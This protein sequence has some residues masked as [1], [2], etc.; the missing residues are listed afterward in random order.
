MRS[1]A[2]VATRSIRACTP[3]RGLRARGPGAADRGR[4][5][6]KGT[7]VTAT[8]QHTTRLISANSGRGFVDQ[9]DGTNRAH[10]STVATGVA[11]MGVMH[12]GALFPLVGFEGKQTELTGRD[13]PA[14]TRAARGIHLGDLGWRGG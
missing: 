4:H 3:G 11:Q 13:T 9:G 7:G 10:G 8:A 5:T 14:T 12:D 2:Q 1:A 6:A